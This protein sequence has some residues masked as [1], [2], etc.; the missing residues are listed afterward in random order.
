MKKKLLKIQRLQKA[1]SE[2]KKKDKSKTEVREHTIR[3]RS[4]GNTFFNILEI[5]GAIEETIRKE[6]SKEFLLID[7]NFNE[8]AKI[9]IDGAG[10]AKLKLD[11]DQE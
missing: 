6:E 2:A 10:T 9:F 8:R 7:E 4:D 1:L 5:I 11:E 3:F